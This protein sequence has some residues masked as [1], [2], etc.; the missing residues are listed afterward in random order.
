MKGQNLETKDKKKRWSHKAHANW[1]CPVQKNPPHLSWRITWDKIA[2]KAIQ[3]Y[4][5][6]ALQSPS[7]SKS[8]TVPKQGCAQADAAMPVPKFPSALLKAAATDG[9]S[10]S[11]VLQIQPSS[12]HP[13]V[14][15][16]CSHILSRCLSASWTNYWPHLPPAMRHSF[17]LSFPLPAEPLMWILL[18]CLRQK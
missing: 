16:V 10:N 18:I 13:W 17:S 8:K 14:L 1:L 11:K 5:S 6:R 9:T 12:C 3:D 2:R 4:W 7:Q 15:Q